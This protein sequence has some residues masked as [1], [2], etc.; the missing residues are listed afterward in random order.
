MKATS[1]YLGRAE[2]GAFGLPPSLS[3]SR[4][5][6]SL[7]AAPV[8]RPIKSA[9][10]MIAAPNPKNAPKPI[11]KPRPM[12]FKSPVNVPSMVSS[13][14]FGVCLNGDHATPVEGSQL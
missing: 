2:T 8:N 7:I 1:N 11:R 4:I 10:L 9:T 6:P 5:E 3:W 13:H 12:S 14:F